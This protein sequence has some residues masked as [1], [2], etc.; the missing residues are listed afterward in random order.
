M[1]NKLLSIQFESAM[2]RREGCTYL[3]VK[4]IR[5]REQSFVVGV[6]GPFL[7][8]D[9]G[10]MDSLIRI[11]RDLASCSSP[12]DVDDH[13]QQ[14]FAMSRKNARGSAENAMRNR[15]IDISRYRGLVGVA[16][17]WV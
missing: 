17:T 11:N 14:S 8:L 15:N 16:K 10:I 12:P 3:C 6:G 2:I 1:S 13:D 5:H 4:D 7:P 9:N